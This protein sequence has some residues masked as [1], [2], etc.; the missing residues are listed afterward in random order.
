MRWRLL[1]VGIAVPAALFYHR[2]LAWWG[3]FNRAAYKNLEPRR[4]TI[5]A[6]LI[7]TDEGEP[8][9]PVLVGCAV[10]K[11]MENLG[12]ARVVLGREPSVR[13]GGEF[14]THSGADGTGIA[15]R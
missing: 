15:I 8:V 11:R 7:S 12:L 14:G 6:K 10:R 9:L 4:Q 2:V 3:A 13:C 5:A 1:F